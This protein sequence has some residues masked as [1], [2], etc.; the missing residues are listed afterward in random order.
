MI[1]LHFEGY[2]AN[3]C[4]FRDRNRDRGGGKNKRGMPSPVSDTA[5]TKVENRTVLAT[6]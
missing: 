2:Y 5:S 4:D 3:T 6:E 1:L